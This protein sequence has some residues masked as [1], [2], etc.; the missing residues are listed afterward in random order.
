VVNGHDSETGKSFTAKKLR[1]LLALKNIHND[2][3]LIGDTDGKIPFVMYRSG[4][5]KKNVISAWQVLVT[6]RRTDPEGQ[7][8]DGFNKTFPVDGDARVS[9]LGHAK[10]WATETYGTTDW[11]K[12]PFG[13]WTSGVHLQARLA[14]LMPETFDPDYRDPTVKGLRAKLFLDD[15]SAEER[16]FRVQV[17]L[18]SKPESPL[19][20]SAKSEDDA[21][22]QFTQLLVK[23]AGT[24]VL[25]GLKI[26]VNET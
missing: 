13:S 18:Y 22:R 10:Q 17:Q 12:T 24:R 26:F 9:A 6:E 11:V 1:E 25:D 23:V 3:E 16:M 20:V 4:W 2:F 5:K 15:D 14:E 21:R 19:Y 8:R 7:Y